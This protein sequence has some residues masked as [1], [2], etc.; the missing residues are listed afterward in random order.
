MTLALVKV[1]VIVGVISV[2]DDDGAALRGSGGRDRRRGRNH[3]RVEGI[4]IFGQSCG[5]AGDE[6]LSRGHDYS[7]GCRR[8]S[9]RSRG[10]P[11]VSK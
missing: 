11:D 10:S 9:R 7:A 5:I 8:R 4:P 3:W 2:V 6:G 1:I